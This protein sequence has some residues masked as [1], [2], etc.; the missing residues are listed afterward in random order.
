MLNYP[1]YG[2]D[3]LNTENAALCN[4]LRTTYGYWIAT[5]GVDACGIDRAAY[6][7]QVFFSD[8]MYSA[9][10][11]A[12]GI[13]P[14]AGSDGKQPFFAFG[15]RFATDLP[16][17]DRKSK[18]SGARM[19]DSNG[20]DILPAML[21]YPLHGTI[22]D[23]LHQGHPTA[24]LGYRIRDMMTV[25]GHPCLM[26][27]FLDN[28]DVDRLLAAGSIA[29]LQQMLVLA[30]TL[31][32]V[33]VVYYAAERAFAARRGTMSASDYRAGGQDGLDSSA[34]LYQLI[35][36]LTSL[37]K[38]NKVF[39]H[40]MPAILDETSAG[41]G[42]FAYEMTCANS[43]AVVAINTS[44]RQSLTR[45]LA[46][47]VAAGTLLENPVAVGAAIAPLRVA[48][49]QTVTVTMPARSAF[50]WIANGVE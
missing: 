3:D 9:D 25:F 5:V 26:P 43:T 28:Q 39:S 46:T 21:N 38:Q 45:T 30:M 18:K 47:S 10:S 6:A 49:D 8:F 15:E 11:A 29:G 37:R 20:N 41:P 4:V 17:R 19:A 32:G 33:P 13:E 2:L 23:V 44:D 12:P 27:A 50:V 48:P 1:F 36:Q 7:P 34:A 22:D 16:S 42:A 31:P 35:A 40:G 14:V 24:E